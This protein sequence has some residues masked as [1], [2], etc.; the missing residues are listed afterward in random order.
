M[1][2][3]D[4]KQ[5]I[6]FDGSQARVDF[7]QTASQSGLNTNGTMTF[8]FW[9]RL[10]AANSGSRQILRAGALIVSASKKKVDVDLG[11]SHLSSNELEIGEW[12]HVAVV[13]SIG[14]SSSMSLFVGGGL[15]SK[16]VS[17]KDL[18]D[19]AT[20]LRI[21]SELGAQPPKFEIARY[22]L[23]KKALDADAIASRMYEIDLSKSPDIIGYWVANAE[24]NT[25]EDLS[26]GNHTGQLSNSGVSIAD[27]DVS[28]SLPRGARH[29]E[30]QRLRVLAK[31]INA[32]RLEK[33]RQE[34]DHQRNEAR[35]AAARAVQHGHHNAATNTAMSSFNSFF[36]LSD[37][38]LRTIDHRGDIKTMPGGENQTGQLYTA[39]AIDE[40]DQTIYLAPRIASFPNPK[41]HAFPLDLNKVTPGK[42]KFSLSG[43]SNPVVALHFDF[44]NK[45]LYAVDNRGLVMTFDSARRIKK[46]GSANV[47]TLAGP[48]GIVNDPDSNVVFVMNASGITKQD[49]VTN[50]LTSIDASNEIKGMVYVRES[51]TL[52]WIDSGAKKIMQWSQA[53]G[54]S[55]F[56][57]LSHS[58]TELFYDPAQK[59]LFWCQE[60]DLSGPIQ[61]W[62]ASN[63]SAQDVAGNRWVGEGGNRKFAA[64]ANGKSKAVLAD[65]VK[66]DNVDGIEQNVFRF[67]GKDQWFDIPYT[68][69][70]NTPQF[71][72]SLKVK[73]TKSANGQFQSVVTSRD[74]DPT[75]GYILYHDN[76]DKW[77][78]WFS[79][80]NDA[81]AGA[82]TSSKVKIGEWQHLVLTHDGEVGRLFVDGELAASDR[83]RLGLNFRRPCRIG[84][85]RSEFQRAHYHFA[86]DIA[87]ISYWDRP[88][89]AAEIESGF[90][91]GSTF[92]LMRM[93]LDKH[94]PEKLVFSI[95][96]CTDFAAH[97]KNIMAFEEIARSRFILK[98]RADERA[99]KLREAHET[100]KRK[101][102]ASHANLNEAHASSLTKI[103]VAKNKALGQRA[104]GNQRLNNAKNAGHTKRTNAMRAAALK[105]R[106]AKEQA[107]NRVQQG[108][109]QAAQLK[110]EAQL[111]LRH[112]HEERAKHG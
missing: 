63:L 95:P 9:F 67:N 78:F 68:A 51:K 105:K 38:V 28:Q 11:A 1:K 92:V 112:A 87:E 4:I 90:R 103:E 109:Q 47:A 36:V 56:C 102:A 89:S 53:D 34:V 10:S 21:G 19:P 46:F 100:G 106:T 24:N 70:L 35:K 86:G 16:T 40:I 104:Q 26:G 88:V 3:A 93:P 20:P 31:K 27:V 17:G 81:W 99:Q 59:Q 85:G 80:G 48:W 64:A 91:A 5:V 32:Q 84:S 42:M 33:A 41:I 75:Q 22:C 62:N 77:S 52:F 39:L 111:K 30:W 2:V 45:L 69:D 15:Q 71:S 107:D 97:G 82:T 12:T 8:D 6:S 83:D 98:Q 61:T 72:L 49:L 65:M 108:H 60:H 79:N 50:Q 37:G 73:S 14:T 44:V 66:I 55:V 13:L 25:M 57:S 101:I 94:C 110:R 76:R 29:G 18:F 7:G 96:R 58:A 74:D 23:S 54:K 43:F